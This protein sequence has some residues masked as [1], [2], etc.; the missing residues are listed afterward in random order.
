MFDPEYLEVQAGWCSSCAACNTC[1]VS[2]ACLLDSPIVVDFEVGALLFAGN[3]A[4][5]ASF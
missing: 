2:S 1:A 3:T 5:V 4:G